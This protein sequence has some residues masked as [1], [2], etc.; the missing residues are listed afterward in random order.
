[1]RHV[2]LV[3]FADGG[4]VGRAEAFRREASSIGLFDTVTIFDESSLPTEFARSHGEYMKNTTRGFGYWIWKPV[5]ILE[6]L[7][8]AR[9]DDVIVYLDAGFTI[10]GAGRR[11]MQE[12]FAIARS[13]PYRMLSFQNVHTEKT[14]TKMDLAV[15]LGVEDRPDIMATSQ[16]SSGF[17]VLQLTQSNLDLMTEWSR[18]AIEERYRYSDDT[19]SI[20]GN[21][22]G[23]VEHRHDQSISSLLRKIRG[24]A[25]THYEVQ[26]YA[27]FFDEMKPT[28]PAWATRSRQ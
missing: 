21:D 6:A 25:V 19:A 28:L 4:F 16:L 24:T 11:R 7:N 18:L 15:R 14:W 1:M 12:Y 13:S 9:T 3:S 26:A 22:V 8:Q 20:C 2:H 5:V 17:I 10:N 23:F 27:S